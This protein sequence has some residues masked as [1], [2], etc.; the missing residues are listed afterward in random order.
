MV[1]QV[2]FPDGPTLYG[3]VMHSRN[4]AVFGFG[5]FGNLVGVGENVTLINV[6]THDL[7]NSLNEIPAIYFDECDDIYSSTQTVINGPFADVMDLRKMVGVHNMD[8]ID[9]GGDYTQLQFVD[10]PLSDA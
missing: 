5:N 10:N 7:K 9:N 8:V 6:K 1:I 3:L 4:I 2:I